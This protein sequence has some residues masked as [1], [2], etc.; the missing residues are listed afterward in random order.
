MDTRLSSFLQRESNNS[1]RL[2]YRAAASGANRLPLFSLDVVRPALDCSSPTMRIR[3]AILSH[4]NNE[5]AF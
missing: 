3:A 4:L 2:R 1:I 5:V